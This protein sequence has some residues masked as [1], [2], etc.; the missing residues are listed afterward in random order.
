MAAITRPRSLGDAT[1]RNT[2][3]LRAALTAWHRRLRGDA[4]VLELMAAELNGRLRR[5][6]GLEKLPARIKARRVSRH[7]RR[8]SSLVESASAEVAKTWSAYVAEYDQQIR[9]ARKS[10]NNGWSFR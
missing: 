4:Y 8:A 9:P 7:L 1:I 6:K 5:A 3:E 10:Q 2:Q